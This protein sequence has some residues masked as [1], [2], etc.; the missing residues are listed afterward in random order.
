MQ[1][2]LVGLPQV[3]SLLHGNVAEPLRQVAVFRADALLP[4]RVWFT[5]SEQPLP[6]L[7]VAAGQ[8]MGGGGH[9]G[10]VVPRQLPRHR[11]PPPARSSRSPAEQ[12]V[13]LHTPFT[14]GKAAQLLLVALPQLPAQLHGNVAEPVRQDAV[15]DAFVLLPPEAALTGP[16][17]LVL[18]LLQ[19]SVVAEQ[20]DVQ[21]RVSVG[22]GLLDSGQAAPPQPG[23]RQL[24][25]RL[26]LSL[27]LPPDSWQGL[28]L[29]Q[30]PVCQTPSLGALP[31][32]VRVA[33]PEQ[34]PPHAVLHVR[35]CVPCSPQTLVEQ[36][37]QADQMGP[38]PVQV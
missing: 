33:G 3:P 20:L 7:S 10:V 11:H 2:A 26:R 4:A 37:L 38:L 8:F 16:E 30:L 17:Q 6:Q 24:T 31:V 9:F 27:Q 18:P 32:Q 5:R 14:G 22:L 36:A 25:I 28:H 12:P 19:L 1:V 21:G 35:V 15:F 23:W 13:V 29:L 34:L